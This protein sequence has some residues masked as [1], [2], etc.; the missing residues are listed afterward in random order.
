MRRIVTRRPTCADIRDRP[1]NVF[2][3]IGQDVVMHVERSH[4][5]SIDL[6]SNFLRTP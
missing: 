6:K 2:S 4:Y 3:R 5:I 1:L